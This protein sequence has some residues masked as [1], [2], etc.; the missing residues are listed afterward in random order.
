MLVM[1]VRK[2]SWKQSIALWVW[3]DRPMILYI[4]HSQPHHATV[5]ELITYSD[6][7]RFTQVQIALVTLDKVKYWDQTEYN[8]TALLV[9]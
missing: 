5:Y 1:F 8:W 7:I 3:A 4:K 6:V 9:W 2:H